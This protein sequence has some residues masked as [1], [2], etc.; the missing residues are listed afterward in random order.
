MKI[1]HIHPSL[2]CGG[3]EAMI[4]SLANQMVNN[5]D[6]SVCTIFRPTD[7]DSFLNKLDKNI[8]VYSLDKRKS[9]FSFVELI[10]I[11]RFIC[12]NDFDVVHLHG[13]F[14][15]YLLSVF[16]LHK[17]VKFVYTVHS[18]AIMENSKWDKRLLFLKKIFFQKKYLEPVTISQTSRQSFETYYKTSAHLVYNGIPK[19]SNYNEADPLSAYR[20]TSDKKIFLHLG[21]ITKAKNQIVLC[22]VFDRLIKSGEDV[23]LII[24]GTKQDLNIYSEIEPF[25]SSRIVY[26]GE[27]SDIVALLKS[28]DA[29][30]LSSIWEGLPITLLEAFSVGCIPICTPVGGIP[31]VILSDVNGLLSDDSSEESYYAVIRYF[32]NLPE[33]KLHMLS[34]NAIQSFDK[35]DIESIA[36]SYIKIYH[37]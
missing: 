21:R 2:E 17:R 11:Y 14:Y 13:F 3:I 22:Q 30:C 6:V 16:L 34:N 25:L 10:K 23:V 12:K 9:G 28:S 24:A 35:Y 1:L 26:L 37:S 33:E 7:S 8:S 27:R 20:Y 31:D 36:E 4:C 29:M 19:P 18:D 32:L 15:Y 5:H